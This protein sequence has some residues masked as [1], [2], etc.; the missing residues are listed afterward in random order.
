MGEVAPM[1]FGQQLGRR[2]ERNLIAATDGTR[3]SRCGH[4]GLTAT[5]ISLD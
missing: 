4:Y 2:H 1:L 3:R 5:D